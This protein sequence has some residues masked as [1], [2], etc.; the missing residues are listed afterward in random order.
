MLWTAN[1]ERYCDIAKGLNDTAEE[2]ASLHKLKRRRSVSLNHICCGQCTG[3]GKSANVAMTID[4]CFS[5]QLC[6][7]VISC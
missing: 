7:G 6:Y 3:G 4:I 5:M 1:T 2:P